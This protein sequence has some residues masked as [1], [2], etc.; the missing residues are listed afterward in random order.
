MNC[1]SRLLLLCISFSTIFVSGSAFGKGVPDTVH[2]LVP[3]FYKPMP[4]YVAD[5]TFEFKCYDKEFNPIE[6]VVDYNDVFFYSVFRK[7]IDSSHT[8]KD[9]AGKKQF[10]PVSVIVKRYDKIGKDKWSVISYPGNQMEI[11]REDKSEIEQTIIMVVEKAAA[12]EQF[13]RQFDFYK[14]LPADQ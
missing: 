12:K 1:V 8:Y 10:L 7:Y 3:E 11:Y 4:Q 13:I 9:A 5:S 2:Y 6:E 14:V